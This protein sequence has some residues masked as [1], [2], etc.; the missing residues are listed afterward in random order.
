MATPPPGPRAKRVKMAHPA[1]VQHYL[2]GHAIESQQMTPPNSNS[3]KTTTVTGYETVNIEDDLPDLNQ[4]LRNIKPVPTTPTYGAYSI[5]KILGPASSLA[6]VTPPSQIRG[7]IDWNSSPHDTLASTSTSVT[8]TRTANDVV[9]DL[10]DKIPQM[11]DTP[12]QNRKRA[13]VETTDD[14]MI[15]ATPSKPDRRAKP[16]YRARPAA[17]SA[18]PA[19]AIEPK[20][21]PMEVRRMR[22]SVMEQVDFEVLNLDVASNR[23]TVVY[24]RAVKAV[25]D[26]WVT[27]VEEEA[28]T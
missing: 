14:E 12:L 4:A 27:K 15:E 24:K 28:Q 13:Y 17:K 8:S 18:K 25:L 2:R 11:A 21:S 5:S 3:K 7:P 9:L 23:R 10:L 20:M 6:P 1:S 19:P 26:E 22:R 16:A